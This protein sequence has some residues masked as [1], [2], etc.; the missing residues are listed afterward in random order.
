[1]KVSERMEKMGI[2]NALAFPFREPKWLRKLVTGS[3]F[4]IISIPILTL[5]MQLYGLIRISISI[6]MSDL[7]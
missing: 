4:F 7:S 6:P 5:G 1:M 3:A 2:V